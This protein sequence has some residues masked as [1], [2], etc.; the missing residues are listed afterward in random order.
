MFAKRLF[1]SP[2]SHQKTYFRFLFYRKRAAVVYLD[3]DLFFFFFFQLAN[4][5]LFS[6]SSS[7]HHQNAF[8]LKH[9]VCVGVRA[10]TFQASAVCDPDLHRGWKNA[11]S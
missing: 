7:N 10:S 11:S 2:K 8:D 5:V 4:V 9:M 3:V 1:G 6:V